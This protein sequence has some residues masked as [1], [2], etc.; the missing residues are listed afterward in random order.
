MRSLLRGFGRSEP[1]E[2]LELS[3]PDGPYVYLD[4]F[5]AGSE[6]HRLLGVALSDEERASLRADVVVDVVLRCDACLWERRIVFR[7]GQ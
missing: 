1:G 7:L 6:Q 2:T 3:V 4:H 5:C